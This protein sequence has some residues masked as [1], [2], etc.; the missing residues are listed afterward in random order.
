[1]EMAISH[2][3]VARI[4]Y[5]SLFVASCSDQGPGP[6][7]PPTAG[8]SNA[9]GATCLELTAPTS[10]QGG[11]GTVFQN[12]CGSCH[13]GSQ[14]TNYTMYA[15]VTANI[16]V[17]LMRIDAGTMPVRGP[18]AAPDSAAIHAWVTAG[19]PEVDSATPAAP[20][21][22]SGGTST[23]TTPSTGCPSTTA[24]APAPAPTTPAAPAA[25]APPPVVVPPLEPT[26]A[27]GVQLIM[28]AYCTGCH[29]TAGGTSPHL[30]TYAAVKS[31]YGNI[32]SQVNS[33]GMPVPR[34]ATSKLPADKITILTQWGSNP[35]APYGQYAQ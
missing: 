5:A 8:T 30:D 29:S 4:L 24:Q 32:M 25:P 12:N 27:K 6:R 2:S 35:N 11:I 1:M 13:P 21:T 23:G 17:I 18:L 34:T 28:A 15:D 20:G 3:V 14:N 9:G 31:N 22:T 7:V 10:W 33:A 26:Y 16:N 19:M